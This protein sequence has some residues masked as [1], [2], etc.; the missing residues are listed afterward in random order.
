MTYILALCKK[1]LCGQ[2]GATKCSVIIKEL[3]PGT[4]DT[5]VGLYVK[6]MVMLW[7]SGTTVSVLLLEA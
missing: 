4:L 7:G 1:V 2:K 3:V 5:S 6:S